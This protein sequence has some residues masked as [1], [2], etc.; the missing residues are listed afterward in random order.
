VAALVLSIA[1][2][3]YNRATYLALTLD[4]LKKQLSDVPQGS[5]E[6][7]VSDNAS[8]DHTQEVIQAAIAGGLPVRAVR[9]ERNIGSDANIAQVFNLSAAPYVMI[10]GDD[11]ILVDGTLRFLVETARQ[12]FGVICLRPYGYNTDYRKEYPGDIGKD[13]EFDDA[14][15]FLA[16]IGAYMTLISACVVNK[17]LLGSVDA[18]DYCGGNL[19]QVHLVVK[20]ALIGERNLYRTRYAVACKRNNSGGYDF[21]RVFVQ[22]LGAILDLYAEQGLHPRQTRRIE[23]QL[24]IRFYPYYVF[25]QRLKKTGDVGEAYQRFVRRFSHHWLFWVILAPILKWPR[26]PALVW[27]GA[28]VLFGRSLTGDM[29]RGLSFGWALLAN[30]YKA[31]TGHA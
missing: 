29:Q 24:I 17:K 10:L 2:P 5:V 14:G 4:V 26:L 13:R 11:D 6:I 20:A 31:M 25:C 28:M 21:S 22:S 15:D 16:A 18:R 9:N 12:G 1:I 19:V 27:G 3:T 23:N 30:K 8:T 7:V